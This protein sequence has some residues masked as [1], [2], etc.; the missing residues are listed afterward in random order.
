MISNILSMELQAP[1]FFPN[2]FFSNL[3]IDLKKELVVSF[4]TYGLFLTTTQ[5]EKV[6]TFPILLHV[7]ALI[8]VKYIIIFKE[9]IIKL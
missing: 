8:W 4:S 7:R 5:S 2:S 3:G 6:N 1:K 9:I